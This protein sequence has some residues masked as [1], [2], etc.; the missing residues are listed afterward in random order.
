MQLKS[1]EM[2]NN[3]CLICLS[4]GTQAEADN[5]AKV[6]LDKKLI[7]CVKQLP[8][9][10]SFTWENKT[11]TSEEIWM[12]MES[13]EDLFDEIEAE[14]AKIHSYQTFVMTASPITKI[15]KKAQIWLNESLRESID[16]NS[17][18]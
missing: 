8:V 7:A 15:S 4:C 11:S 2:K 14:V 12:S 9:K 6:L 5:I 3:F 1:L 13:R 18:S 10:S 16:E 17:R